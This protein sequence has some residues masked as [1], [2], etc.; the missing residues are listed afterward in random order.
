M[1]IG[2]RSGGWDI[3]RAYATAQSLYDT[4]QNIYSG[5]QA[6]K[7]AF[8][9]AKPG[10]P[11]KPA[12]GAALK[13]TALKSY[14]DKTYEKKCGVEVKQFTDNDTTTSPGTSLSTLISPFQ[15]IDQ[16]LTDVT[17]LGNSIEVKS[18]RFKLLLTGH[19]TLMSRVRIIVIKQGAMAGAVPAGSDI[20][21]LDSDIKSFYTMDKNKQYSILKDV[22]FEMTPLSTNDAQ[23]FKT[24]NF[25]YTPKGCHSIRYLQA[26]TTGGIGDM[27][28]GNINIKIMYEGGAP[29]GR[30]AYRT[31]WVDS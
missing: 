5:A 12:V 31:E 19:A 9:N 2:G 20:L 30:F 1:P 21:E 10:R 11:R 15:G 24:W 22:T 26:S 27:I 18:L 25:N 29:T 14:L 23:T 7:T 8:S 16:G 4:G 6:V 28:F 13:Q 3:K 17:R